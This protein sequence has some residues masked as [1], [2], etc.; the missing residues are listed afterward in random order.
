MNFCGAKSVPPTSSI[1]MRN[2][3]KK[4]ARVFAYTHAY[5]QIR[6]RGGHDGPPPT[7]NRVNVVV[8]AIGPETDFT[9]E[10]NVKE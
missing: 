5:T 2:C 1:K 7:L 6:D 8:D 4:L 9:L 3:Q 10:T